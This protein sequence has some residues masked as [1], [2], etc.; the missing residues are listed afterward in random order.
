MVCDALRG[1]WVVVR[2]V[3]ERVVE[4]ISRSGDTVSGSETKMKHS[5]ASVSAGQKIAE[6]GVERGGVKCSGCR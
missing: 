3:S 2:R 4:R 1:R 6:T 5:G